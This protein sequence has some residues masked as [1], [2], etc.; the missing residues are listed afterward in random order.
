MAVSGKPAAPAKGKRAR[1]KSH[2]FLRKI[3][4]GVC[5]LAI[6]VMLVSGFLAG[7]PL[8]TTGFRASI[9]VFSVL[10]V[11]RVLRSVLTM[12]EEIDRGKA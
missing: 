12:Y 3:G 4:A 7:V 8:I 2:M 1:R 6:A 10:M 5:L 11:E 9:A